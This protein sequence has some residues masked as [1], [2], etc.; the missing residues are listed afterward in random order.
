MPAEPLLRVRGLSKTFQV[1]GASIRA[2][3]EVSFDLQPGRTLA[4]VGESGC[5]KSTTGRLVLRLIEPSKGSVRLSGTDVSKARGQSLRRLRRH[6]QIVFQDPMGSLNPRMTVGAAVGE[7]LLINGVKIKERRGR[8]AELLREVELGPEYAERYP[9]E[10]SG[11]QRQRVAIARALA[12][13]PQLIVADEPVS[14]LD[15]SIQSQV[16]ALLLRLQR[17]QGI[18]YLFISHD[19]SV[20]RY[21]AHE[22]AVMYLGEIV[23]HGPTDEIFGHP[24]HPYTQALL[25]AIPLPIP[26]ADSVH[27]LEGSVPSAVDPPAGCPFITR[28]PYAMQKCSQ[29]PSAFGVGPG[30]TARCWLNE[31]SSTGVIEDR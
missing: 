9:H 30:H 13:R 14:A 16:L 8:I 17:E 22:V 21:I 19:L 15:A 27:G 26:N 1:H 31:T 23:E 4:L 29:P 18:S 12:L 6:A 11:G 10:L 28:C 2:V 24:K 3:H 7:P 20:V 5:G 25:R